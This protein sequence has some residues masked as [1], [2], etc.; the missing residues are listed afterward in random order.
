MSPLFAP[1]RG[2]RNRGA[3]ADDSHPRIDTTRFGA[4]RQWAADSAPFCGAAGDDSNCRGV[5]EGVERLL[6]MT[7]DS[8]EAMVV[9][10]MAGVLELA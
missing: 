9:K 2:L 5:V 4:I 3:G 1:D 10:R 6:A 8:Q 7:M